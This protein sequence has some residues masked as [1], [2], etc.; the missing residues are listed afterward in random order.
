VYGLLSAAAGEDVSPE[1]VWVGYRFH[2]EAEAEDL[3]KIL[4]FSAT[5]TSWD[6]T[7]GQVRSMPIRRQFLVN[8]VLHLYVPAEEWLWKALWTPHYPLLLGRSQDV[9]TVEALEEAELTPAQEGEVEGILLPF[10][11][12]GVQSLVYNLPTYLPTYPPRRALSV[13]PF[14]LVTQRQR[15]QREDRLLYREPEQG[16][17]VPVYTREWLV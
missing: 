17:L 11:T 8:P 9:A 2:A 14:Q 1:R 7:T 15:V 13:K 6:A 4:L 16:L 10:P 12:P 5:G 3:E